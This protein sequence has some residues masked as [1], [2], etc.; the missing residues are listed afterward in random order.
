[1]AEK[2]SRILIFSKTCVPSPLVLPGMPETSQ[3]SLGRRKSSLST[4][5]SGSGG[6]GAS[7]SGRKT[8]LELR[9]IRDN[10]DRKVRKMSMAPNEAFIVEESMLE[11]LCE[12]SGEEARDGGNILL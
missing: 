5:S 6:S 10:P 7:K 12:A 9:K 8:P 4:G 3:T 11:D 2:D 1:M